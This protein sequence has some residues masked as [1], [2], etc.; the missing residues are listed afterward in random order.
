MK[1]QTIK[2]RNQ[3]RA[4]QQAR[5]TAQ[6]QQPKQPSKLQRR[7]AG[8]AT[9]AKNFLLP[10]QS[11][12]LALAIYK[13]WAQACHVKP[14]RFERL[15]RAVAEQRAAIIVGANL[16]PETVA[17]I[18]DYRDHYEPPLN[19]RSDRVWQASV[20]SIGCWAI[21]KGLES[22]QASGLL[23]R[24]PDTTPSLSLILCEALSAGLPQF[25][26][27]HKRQ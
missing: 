20:S 11:V 1:Q 3:P 13:G 23:A 12:A 25:P 4:Q 14:Q 15:R 6:A 5:E 24:Y 2:A 17:Q 8:K 19:L 22:V 21:M 10:H 27:F 16:A 26:R 9:V 18:E 7:N